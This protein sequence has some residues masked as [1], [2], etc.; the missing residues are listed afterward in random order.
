MSNPDR[1]CGAAGL[2]ALT[3][4]EMAAAL[5]DEKLKDAAATGAETIVVCNPGCHMHMRAGIARRGMAVKVRHVV[6]LLDDAYAA[7]A[8]APITT[9]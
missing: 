6:E 5:L 9:V 2:N 8:G 4:P 1:C 7:S 3:H